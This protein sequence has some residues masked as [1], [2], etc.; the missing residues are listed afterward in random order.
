MQFRS[1]KTKIVMMSGLC[2]VVTVLVLIFI[3]T[4]TQN[5]SQKFVAEQVQELVTKQT[6]Q[7]LLAVAQREAAFIRSKL[8]INLDLARTIAQT[9]KALREN[10]KSANS[11]DLRTAFNDILLSILKDNPEFLGTYSAWEPDAL[12]GNDSLYADDKKSGH[13]ASGRFVPY[14]NR[15]AN[16]NIARQALVGYEDASLHPNGVTKGGWYLFPRERLKDNILDPFP[17]IVQGKQ[18]WLTTM[19]SPIVINGKF[20]GIG[21]ADLRLD[22]LQKLSES[23]A[24]SLYK[25]TAK[26]WVISNMGIV[27]ANSENAS[28]V[29]KY[30]KDVYEGDW[31]ELVRDTQSGTPFVAMDQGS[32]LIEVLAPIEL[33]R[34][35]TPWSICIQVERSVVFAEADQLQEFLRSDTEK[36]LVIGASAGIVSASLA[37]LVLWFLAGSLV[38]PIRKAV[39]FSDKIANGDFSDNTIDINQKD[40]IGVLAKTLRDMAEKLKEVVLDVQNVSGNVASGSEELSSSAQQVSHGATQQ[41][42][43]IEEVTSSMEEMTSSISQNAQNAQQ[44]DTIATKAAADAQECGKAVEKTVNSMGSIAEKISIVEEIARQ[45]NLLALNAAIEAAR[46]GEHGKGF[47]VVAAEVRKLAERSG[48]AASEI[49]ELSSSSVEVAEKAGRMLKALVPDIEKTASLVQEISAASDEQHAGATQINQA[50]SQLDNV[51]QQNASASEEMASTSEELSAQGQQ[52]QVTMSFFNVG[53]SGSGKVRHV[54]ASTK[55]PRA[56]PGAAEPVRPKPALGIDVDMGN[57]H[58]EGFERF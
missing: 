26:V 4:Y 54:T 17:Y 53:N 47:A 28:L 14:W 27:V 46:A 57:D 45:T 29:G 22:F 48:T 50:I 25:G 23:V 21:G 16:G 30:L 58:D 35:G 44:T 32:E 2:L 49:S 3:Q 43:S 33:G 56:L 31:Q 11:L 7:R 24:Q 19:S 55:R 40:E 15:D 36:N 38:A 20:L 1:I 39:A 34:T 5:Q 13:D 6:E 42:A 18:E 51:I 41:A 10:P 9:F 52:L 12:D 8:E 37:C